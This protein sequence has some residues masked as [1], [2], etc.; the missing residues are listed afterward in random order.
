MTSRLEDVAGSLGAAA[1]T[2]LILLAILSA[3]PESAAGQS[4]R[5]GGV[6]AWSATFT[7]SIQ[8]DTT[9]TEADFTNRRRTQ[10]TASGTAETN[11]CFEDGS[12][13]QWWA[14]SGAVEVSVDDLRSRII[15]AGGFRSGFTQTTA[16]AGTVG[17]GEEEE[18]G[19]N[20][21][22][23]TEAGTY[24]VGFSPEALPVE[25]RTVFEGQEPKVEAQRYSGAG[26]GGHTGEHSLPPP[27]QPLT[28]ETVTPDGTRLRWT[29]RPVGQ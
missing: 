17:W 9:W 27:G 26:I 15:E 20:L 4:C 2:L 21:G 7:A 25:V 14:T 16:G 13:L 3:T 12:Y 6:S 28:G 19:F 29:I 22:I 1:G 23:D 11:G 24:S 18:P 5:W 8:R 10:I